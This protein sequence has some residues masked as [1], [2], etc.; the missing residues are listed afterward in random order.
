[1][2]DRALLEI[3]RPIC[4]TDTCSDDC[5]ILTLSCGTLV[6]STD[7]L[8]ERSDF[9]AGMTNWQ[10]GWMSVA[11]TLSDIA[12]MGAEPL[13]IVL[14]IG[15]N[16]EERLSE[17]VQGAQ[18]CC[19]SYG[20][21]YAGGDLDAHTELTIV[22]TGIG[23]IRD[24]EPVRRAGA[25]PGDIICVTGTL[26]RAIL[27]LSGDSR[28]WKDLCEPQPRVREGTHAR[29]AGATAMIDI[30]DGLALSLYDI[31]AESNVGMEIS[32]N[33]IPLPDGAD[34]NQARDA[35][36][37]GGGDFEL[38]FFIP[39]EK[40]TNLSIPVSRIG[41]VTTHREITMDGSV[42]P[43]KGYLHHW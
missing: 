36:L 13:Q 26:G 24:G 4:G 38:L 32:S 21:I 29:I 17:I 42:L 23:I 39:E 20:A 2:D 11:V 30:S 6:T 15:L 33:L 37:Y 7:M 22:S 18:V 16:T 1:M 41:R 14:A 19:E 12:A 35:A 40:F 3:I 8:H 5:A 25:Q 34:Q 43:K 9:P 31:A 10:I 28:F 27:G